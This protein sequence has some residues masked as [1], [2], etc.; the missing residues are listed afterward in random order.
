[1]PQNSDHSAFHFCKFLL[2]TKT[3]QAINELQLQT[4]A[5]TKKQKIVKMLKIKNK[6]AILGF[7]KTS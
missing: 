3:C 6:N 2:F 1:M 7:R 4:A 5:K